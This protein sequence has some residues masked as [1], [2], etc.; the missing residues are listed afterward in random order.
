MFNQ[1]LIDLKAPGYQN[2]RFH[3]AELGR[4]PEIVKEP[5]EFRPPEQRSTQ[6][7]LDSEGNYRDD[8]FVDLKREFWNIGLQ[9]VL[10][11]TN[12]ELQP[13]RPQYDGEEWHIEGQMVFDPPHFRLNPIIHI[14][15]PLCAAKRH[16]IS[17]T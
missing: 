9:F 10:K 2:Q 3:V 4:V 8:I 14:S 11:V 16:S 15:V 17:N 13:D 7:N 6:Q 5:G 1:T 12:I